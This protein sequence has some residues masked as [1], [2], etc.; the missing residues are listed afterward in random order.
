M[1]NQDHINHRNRPITLKK[2]EAFIKSFPTTNRLGTDGSSALELYQS[3]KEDLIS[4]FLK[5]FHNR[6]R[7]NTT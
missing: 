2:I 4:I 6:N 5:L 1:L 7:R 3:F